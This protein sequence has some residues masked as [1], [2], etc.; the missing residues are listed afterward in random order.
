MFTLIKT[1]KL[2]ELE[3]KI[4]KIEEKSDD[5][6]N[7]YSEMGFE[8]RCVHFDVFELKELAF[9]KQKEIAKRLEISAEK[10]QKASEISVNLL[11]FLEKGQKFP[12][13]IKK[14]EKEKEKGN[15][16]GRVQSISTS[17]FKINGKVGKLEKNLQKIC[18]II[19]KE[20]ED[21]EKSK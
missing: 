8:V 20:K 15:E 12:K 1:Q 17:C 6:E 18:D 2:E 9:L 7:C 19:C 16:N 3:Q 21:Q 10:A 5:L 13:N 4:K 14:A 11:K